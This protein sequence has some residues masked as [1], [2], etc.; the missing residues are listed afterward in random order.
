[1]P[2]FNHRFIDSNGIKMHIVEEGEGPLVVLC[3]GFP[4]LW[5]SWRHQITPLAEAGFHVVAPDQRGYGRTDK[6]VKIEAYNIFQLV[7]D[8][9]GLVKAL[10]EK[11]AII[12]G[13]DWG[14]PVAWHCAL[15]RPDIFYA[16]SLLS[17]PYMPRTWDPIAPTEL[18]KVMQ[19]D[20]L[21]YQSYFQEPGNAEAVMDEDVEKSLRMF[22]YSLAGDPPPEKRWRF[23]F[24]KSE[25][26]LDSCS[27]PDS[28]PKWLTENDLSYFAEEFREAGFR[29]GLN[30]YRN[31]DGNWSQT[32][33]LS[34][35]KLLQPALF[36]AGEEDAVIT[37]Y[38]EGFDN[39]EQVVPNLTRKVLL[40]GAG[41]W[42]QQERPRAVNELLIEFLKEQK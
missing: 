12:V 7:G 19:G 4:E 17:V 24:E 13:H 3:H 38:R 14:A 21:F 41:H 31:I 9:V 25:T 22:L 40:P 23:I 28:L 42:I 16:V 2:A 6:P 33:F 10:G 18:M 39:L 26:I 1:M 15:L 35:A 32:A 20:G 11:R 34:E 27:S 36:V 37:M 30:W 5:Y 29:G 8:V